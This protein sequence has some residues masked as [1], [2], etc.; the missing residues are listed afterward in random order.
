[1]RMS[2]LKLFNLE[3]LWCICYNTNLIIPAL[4]IVT[5]HSL[6][7]MSYGSKTRKKRIFTKK[8]ITER[9]IIPCTTHKYTHF[10]FPIATILNRI[11]SN[12]NATYSV[13]NYKYIDRL[14]TRINMCIQDH[15]IWDHENQFTNAKYW[16]E[17]IIRIL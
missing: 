11:L 15:F 8:N 12:Y 17:F 13:Y 16:Y 6:Y 14:H 2:E 1:M 4:I 9:T 7:E 3:I 5:I 10:L